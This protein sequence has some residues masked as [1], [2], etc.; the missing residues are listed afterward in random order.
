M[1]SRSNQ[2]HWDA[3]WA[4][5]QSQMSCG[6]FLLALVPPGGEL[7]EGLGPLVP[8]G[9]LHSYDAC[10]EACQFCISAPAVTG[11]DQHCVCL[12]CHLAW[13]SILLLTSRKVYSGWITKRRQIMIIC[14][15]WLSSLY[16]HYLFAQFH[17]WQLN[18]SYQMAQ[19]WNF[20]PYKVKRSLSLRHMNRELSPLYLLF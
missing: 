16:L 12:L 17:S 10:G 19:K 18:L 13:K 11:G 7:G 1:D 2:C 9:N 4:G 14:C 15:L 8:Q 5:F 6:F 3:I 20:Q